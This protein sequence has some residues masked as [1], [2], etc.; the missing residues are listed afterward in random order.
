MITRACSRST[1]A[2]HGR[3]ERT[4]IHRRKESRKPRGEARAVG[5]QELV[6]K[7]QAEGGLNLGEVG[8]HGAHAGLEQVG[9]AFFTGE[10]L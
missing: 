10:P 4:S 2:D 6:H 8:L 1:Q 7:V 5:V 3:A 9:E